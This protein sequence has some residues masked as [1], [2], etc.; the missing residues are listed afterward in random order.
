VTTES[1]RDLS[2]A[3]PRIRLRGIT[4][5]Y[6]AVVANREVDLDVSAGGIH[7]VV[8]E[9]GAG[10]T[11]L[12][13]VIAGETQ[14]DTGSYEL[15]GRP[16]RLR[17]PAS[18]IE[19]GIGMVHQRLQLVDDLSAIENLVLGGP[20]SRLGMIFDRA[21]ALR[22]AAD[23]A[24]RLATRLDWNAPVRALTL[25]ARQRLEIMRLL[26]RRADTLIFDEPTSVLT[27][28][29]AAD[30][31]AIMRR[32][33]GEGKAVIFITHKLREVFATADVVTVMR[34][35]RVISTSAAARTSQEAVAVQIVGERLPTPSPPDGG[36]A[37]QEPAR[38]ALE[39]SDL[40]AT[41]DLGA[42]AL[43][44][45]SFTLAAGEI[46]GVAGVEGN[47]QR[48]LVEVL[49]GTRPARTG[50]ASLAGR[51]CLGY[52]VRRRR[53]LGLAYIPSD[54]DREGASL[55]STL[56]ENVV[57]ADYDRPPFSRRGW[58]RL[59]AMTAFARS[60]L[61]RFEVRAGGPAAPARSLSGGN[62]QRLIVARELHEPP[63]VLIASHPTR[64]VDLRGID[65][66]HRQ[67]VAARRAGAG[68]LLI[69]EDISEILELSDRVMV[70]FEGRVVALL[71]AAEV[72]PEL[73]GSMMTGVAA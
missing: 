44:E 71:K 73:L 69:S 22:D 36:E 25:G 13:R 49:V 14:P 43:R 40:G 60:L 5:R 11:T 1:D 55:D 34:G 20:P 51:S 15:D 59:G 35:G 56:V 26:Y 29:E 38:P 39:V 42:I 30:L 12:M 7:A 28:R 47:G 62:L 31:F 23:L 4:K 64:G 6:G 65:F 8:G 3:A 19:L 17:G 48:E 37:G 66:I 2:H 52:S 46:L 10:K 24:E 58:L 63:S 70:L 68:V 21:A 9:N 41:G 53:R 61:E 67:L 72:T 18:A 57:A 54:R 50:T 32:L 27:P 33:A 45:V 16:V